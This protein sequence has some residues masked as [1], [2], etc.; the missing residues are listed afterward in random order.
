M[1]RYRNVIRRRLA[2]CQP[3]TELDSPRLRSAR[4]ANTAYSDTAA[5]NLRHAPSAPAMFPRVTSAASRVLP[6]DTAIDNV[7]LANAT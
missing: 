2:G 6:T 3:G 1:G 5:S 4:G 7:Y